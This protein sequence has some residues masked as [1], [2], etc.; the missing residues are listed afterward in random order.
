MRPR[1]VFFNTVGRRMAVAVGL[2]VVIAAAVGFYLSYRRAEQILQQ[3][4]AEEG[5]AIGDLI[6][7]SFELN[8][9]EATAQPAPNAMAHRHTAALLRSEYK[10]LGQA[11]VLRIVDRD[12]HVRWSRRPEEVG[13]TIPDAARLLS[14]SAQGN[15]DVATGEYVRPLGGMT[16]AR[17]HP[18]NAFSVGAVQVVVSRPAMAD[19]MRVLFQAVVAFLAF[20]SAAVALALGVALR[21]LVTQ[22]IARLAAV[23]QRAENGEVLVRAKVEGE[24]EIGRLAR[25]FNSMLSKLTAKAAD[26]IEAA[27]ERE[28]MRRRS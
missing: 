4:A 26:E 14:A 15:A 10:M 6:A 22:P 23:M 5:S 13:S 16:C 27:R 24:D 8:E 19:D 25:A 28:A 20:L 17:C 11:A 2:P 7:T 12:G 18:T 1:P 9:P 3:N 21:R